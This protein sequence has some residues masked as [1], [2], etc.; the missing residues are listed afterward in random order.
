MDVGCYHPK[1]LSNTYRLHKLGWHGVNIDMEANKVNMFNL[2]RP[3]DFNVVAAVSDKQEVVK[4]YRYREFGLGA[5]IDD[6]CAQNTQAEVKDIV[7]VTTRTLDDILAHSP[8]K[9]QKIDVLSIDVEGNDFKV[10]KSLSLDVYQPDIIIIEEHLQDIES[11]IKGDM[12]GHL[13]ANDYVLHSWV[14]LSLIFKKIPAA[15]K[16]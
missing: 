3:N 10:L 12:Y 6:R 16:A 9:N 13:K 1:K 11:I 15:P 5:T 7:E 14:H 4:M 2:A 8:Y